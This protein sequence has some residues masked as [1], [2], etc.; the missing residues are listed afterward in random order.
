MMWHPLFWKDSIL[1]PS[2][3]SIEHFQLLCRFHS[4]PSDSLY[5]NSV[6]SSTL[7]SSWASFSCL[8]P[9]YLES[10]RRRRGGGGFPVWVSSCLDFLS[11]FCQVQMKFLF[12][13]SPACP[14]LSSSFQKTLKGAWRSV[15]IVKMFNMNIE[16]KNSVLINAVLFVFIHLKLQMS[17][18]QLM[19][20][21]TLCV[22]LWVHSAPQFQQCRGGTMVSVR[23]WSSTR[24]TVLLSS[25]GGAG[26]V[27]HLC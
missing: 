23:S 12:I 17:G 18:K 13:G 27:A 11:F 9:A 26:D 25:G 15:L 2:S 20:Q 7:L 1:P 19:V 4:G 5:L 14:H 16:K 3:S 10:L 6:W 8:V 24:S 21:P 22:C